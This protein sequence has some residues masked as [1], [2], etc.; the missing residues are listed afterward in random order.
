[1]PATS[2][3]ADRFRMR[4]APSAAS[5]TEGGAGAH[6]SSQ[7]STPMTSPGTVPHST[8]GW[9]AMRTGSPAS[10]NSQPLSV[11]EGEANQRAS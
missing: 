5:R 11:S 8:S 4:V 6:K 7:I 9:V 10:S 3:L 1:M 2:S